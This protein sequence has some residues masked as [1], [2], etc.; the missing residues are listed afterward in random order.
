M[1]RGLTKLEGLVRSAAATGTGAFAAGTS[2]PTIADVCLVPQIYN[3]GRFGIDV[4]TNFPALA[5]VNALC[6]THPAF[7][8]AIPE[9][10]P[11]AP[12]A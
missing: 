8:A 9:V 4:N 11:D 5:K 12:K 7:Q 1:L 2:Y 6:A 3:A 10:Q